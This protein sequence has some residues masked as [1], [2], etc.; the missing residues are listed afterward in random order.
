LGRGFTFRTG[1]GFVGFTKGKSELKLRLAFG[2]GIFLVVSFTCLI[3]AQSLWAFYRFAVIFSLS[4]G[5][6]IPQIPIFIGKYFGRKAMASLV[7]LAMFMTSVGGALS[8]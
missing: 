6:E 4:Y 2:A 5:G 3:F 7:G 8:S 1:N